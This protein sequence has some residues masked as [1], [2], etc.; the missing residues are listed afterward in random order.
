M[1]HLKASGHNKLFPSCLEHIL[2]VV[3]EAGVLILNAIPRILKT[4]TENVM[5]SFFL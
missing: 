1:K 5:S 2:I 4:L 3:G